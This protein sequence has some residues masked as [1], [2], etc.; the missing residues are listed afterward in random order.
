MRIVAIDF[1]ASCLPR[2]G[3]SYPIEVGISED[4]KPARSWLIRPH[5]DWDGWDWTEEAQNLHGLT[6][7][8]ILHEGLPAAQVAAELGAALRG[9]RVIADSELDEYWL[10]VLAKAARTAPPAAIEHIGDLLDEWGSTEDE[11]IAA[12]S[13]VDRHALTRH[14]AGDDAAWLAGLI[15]ALRQSA[16]ARRSIPLHPL[17]GWLDGPA[18]AS[19][20]TA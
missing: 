6:Y 8:R 5:P 13:H 20:T 12:R 16:E 11:I 7:D 2:H 15:A 1:E 3:R 14:R 17:F 4:G 18:P 10:H 19:V 9:R